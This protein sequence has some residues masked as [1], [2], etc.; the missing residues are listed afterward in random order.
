MGQMKIIT[1]EKPMLKYFLIFK[2]L[3]LSSISV[4]G[5]DLTSAVKRIR[6]VLKNLFYWFKI[7]KCC[8]WETSFNV[9]SPWELVSI[10]IRHQ[11]EDSI[12]LVW[13]S[14]D[15][16]WKILKIK[17]NPSGEN[18]KILRMKIGL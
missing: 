5:M 4:Y 11:R 6:L 1:I 7:K 9:T 12:V 15:L 17:L 18:I 3:L 13:S 14:M 2:A 8:S 10:I 16:A